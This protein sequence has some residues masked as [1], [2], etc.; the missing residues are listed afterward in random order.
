MDL[1]LLTEHLAWS[2]RR[3]LAILRD[4]AEAEFDRSFTEASGNLRSKTAHIVSVYEFFIGIL[5]GDPHDRFP[6]LSDQP[7][8]S[9]LATWDRV[10]EVW[11]DYVRST[12][13]DALFGLP[14]AEGRRVEARHIFLDALLHTTHHRGQLLTFIRLLGK[15]TD[16]IPPSATNLD[17]LLFLFQ[18]H[19]ELVHPASVR[20]RRLT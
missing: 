13:G 14:L 7:K 6:D 10:T 18:L 9:L 20:A 5:E 4:L 19:P 11:P 8:E 17:Y 16:E 3:L 1:D 12:P 2:D 15:T